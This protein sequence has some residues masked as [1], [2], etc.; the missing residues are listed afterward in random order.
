M[1]INQ[2]ADRVDSCFGV[3]IDKTQCRR[4]ATRHDKLTANYLAVIQL[5]S[6]RPWLRID[7]PTPALVLTLDFGGLLG[8]PPP[9]SRKCRAAVVGQRIR[10]AEAVPA[11]RTQPVIGE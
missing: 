10:L 2:N 4:V 9:D 3:A 1:T 7:A 11:R 5:A 6:I 8:I